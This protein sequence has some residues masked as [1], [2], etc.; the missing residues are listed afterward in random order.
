LKDKDMYKNEDFGNLSS[1]IEAFQP[2]LEL[3]QNCGRPRNMVGPLG[4][5][6]VGFDVPRRNQSSHSSLFDGSGTVF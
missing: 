1:G 4:Y 3:F 2:G 5:G 6:V